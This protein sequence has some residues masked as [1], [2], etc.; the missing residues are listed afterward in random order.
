MIEI[1]ETGHLS[2]RA[3]IP[4][5]IARRPRDV[6]VSFLDSA[7]EVQSPCVGVRIE[8]DRFEWD[9]VLRDPALVE[10]ARLGVKDRVP[11]AVVLRHVAV[12]AVEPD[13]IRIDTEKVA[14]AARVERIDRHEQRIVV[15]DRAVLPQHIGRELGRRLVEPRGDVQSVVVVEQPDLGARGCRGVL[16]WIN[17]VEVVEHGGTRPCRVVERAVDHGRCAR[18]HDLDRLLAIRRRGRLDGGGYLGRGRSRRHCPGCTE[19]HCD[20]GAARRQTQREFQE[21]PRQ[22]RNV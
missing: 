13:G 7:R 4:A 12:Q 22:K 6:L 5:A 18:A 15:H 11:I 3:R 1:V 19:R 2:C 16:G 8:R 21:S 10:A 14:G 20:Q 17:L 9:R